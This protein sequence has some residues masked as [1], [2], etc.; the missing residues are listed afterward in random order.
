MAAPST[1]FHF[2]I[3]L[4]DLDRGVYESLDFRA[5]QHPSES[6]P[7]FLTRI[8][9]FVLNYEDG[10]NFSPQGLGDPN[11]PSLSILDNF[12]GIRLWIEIGNPSPRKLHKA[13]KTS[14]K[15]RVYTYKNPELLIK[16]ILSDKVHRASEIDIFS[17]TPEFIENLTDLVSRETRWSISYNEG[18]ILVSSGQKSEQG[19]LL[20]HT[21]S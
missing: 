10:L 1:I 12:G 13:S 14:Q 15:V 7:Y 18:T 11:T 2:K 5:A 4:S 8:L 16:A 3:D 20:K 19:D 17:L 6:M 9:A 21:L